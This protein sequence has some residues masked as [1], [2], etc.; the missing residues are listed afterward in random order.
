MN[1]EMIAGRAKSLWEGLHCCVEGDI[2][3]LLWAGR[4]RCGQGEA[5]VERARLL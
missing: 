3:V 1:G 4:G 5:A 2:V